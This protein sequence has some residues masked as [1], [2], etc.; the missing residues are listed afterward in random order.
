MSCPC[1][2]TAGDLG[3]TLPGTA[4]PS[5]DSKDNK[6]H[7][8]D[9]RNPSSCCHPTPRGLSPQS[10]GRTSASRAGLHLEWR[11]PRT[12]RRLA[13][14]PRSSLL[15]AGHPHGLARSHLVI[16]HILLPTCRQRPPSF[17]DSAISSYYVA[18]LIYA[19][20]TYK[21]TRLTSSFSCGTYS[22]VRRERQ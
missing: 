11:W 20:G 9:S 5:S 3:I 4:P 17:I 21:S 7:P 10:V 15:R 12:A 8:P 19:L 6:K 16:L 22:L 1:V 13:C 2:H 18:V 14:G